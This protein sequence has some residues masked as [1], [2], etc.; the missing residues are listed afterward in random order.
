MFLNFFGFMTASAH[1]SVR[2]RIPFI[3][4]EIWQLNGSCPTHFFRQRQLFPTASQSF[5]LFDPP[6]LKLFPRRLRIT[7]QQNR[8]LFPKA[9]GVFLWYKDSDQNTRVWFFRLTLFTT[10]WGP[11]TSPPGHHKVSF[12]KTTVPRKARSLYLLAGTSLHTFTSSILL[13]FFC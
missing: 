4:K 2:A 9:P 11:S 5:P 12:L 10:I 13:A 7:E 6:F 1:F 3:T 8:L